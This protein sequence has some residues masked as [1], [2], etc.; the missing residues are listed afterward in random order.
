MK[1]WFQ[2]GLGE[3]S[4][5][6]IESILRRFNSALFYF[7]ES[8]ERYL[9][10]E[11]KRHFPVF[12]ADQP[13]RCQK[14][15]NAEGGTH[16]SHEEERKS[17]GLRAPKKHRNWWIIRHGY[18]FPITR[19]AGTKQCDFAIE[20]VNWTWISIN[21]YSWHFSK[22]VLFLPAAQGHGQGVPFIVVL[23]KTKFQFLMFFLGRVF[24]TFVTRF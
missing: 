15:A 19:R 6:R 23:G 13:R 20:L 1:R 16:W 2:I 22:P 12:E 5:T 11:D 4:W 10:R 24:F 21:I 9:L 17:Q 18:D 7:Q 3:A 14:A 8:Y